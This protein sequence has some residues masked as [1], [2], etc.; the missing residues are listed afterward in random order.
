MNGAEALVRTLVDSG[1]DV[2]FA[3]PGT[4]EMHFVAALDKVPE[5][6]GVLC[7]FEGGATGA[8][9]GFG[10]MTRRPACTLLHLGPGLGNGIANL[11]NARRAGS[12]IVNIVGDHAVDHIGFDTPLTSDIVSL[13]TNVSGWVHTTATATNIAADGAAAVAAALSLPGKVA[14][15]ILPANTCWDD[16]DGPAPKTSIVTPETPIAQIEEAAAALSSNRKVTLLLGGRAL[17]AEG[18]HDAAAI[19]ARCGAKV[20]TEVFP[21]RQ[22]RGAGIPT[23]E[24]LAYR[25]EGAREQL[26]DTEVLILIGAAEPFTFF[27]YPGQS[28]RVAPEDCEILTVADASHDP[29]AVLEALASHLG[30]ERVSIERDVVVADRPTGPIIPRSIAAA[31]AATLPHDAIVSDEANTA[32]ARLPGATANAAPHDWLCLAG[33]AIGQGLPVATGAAVACPDRKVLALEA[34]GSAMYTPQALWTHAREGLD[35]TTVIMNNGSYG[36]LDMELDRVGAETTGSAARDLLDLKRPDMDFVALAASMGVPG[37][38][39]H[40]AEE[41]TAQLEAGLEADGP[42]LIEAMV[43]PRPAR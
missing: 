20:F 29:E 33:G 12:P 1:V 5:M 40:T 8:A 39:A 43:A 2:C 30:V 11:H 17:S 38:R 28:S 26:A 10:R 9:D 6:R 34:D 27:A 41:L 3:N 7:L 23:I 13:A 14:T 35:V 24:R 15:L 37:T 16:A 4:S 36:V 19:A 31:I 32:G 25:G 18:Q 42:V 21:A 22:R